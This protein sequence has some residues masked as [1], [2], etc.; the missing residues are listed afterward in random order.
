MYCEYSKTWPLAIWFLPCSFTFYSPFHKFTRNLIWHH[1]W[2]MLIFCSATQTNGWHNFLHP[3][4]PNVIC[5]LARLLIFWIWNFKIADFIKRGGYA[6]L[7]SSREY[8]G[9]LGYFWN[10]WFSVLSINT[11]CR[12]KF[13]RI[14]NN[15]YKTTF[16]AVRQGVPAVAPK[17]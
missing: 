6:R 14:V 9:G 4:P 1:S 12:H 15:V 3:R 10:E 16:A 8:W 13:V 11:G 2:P 5:T 17:S 7:F